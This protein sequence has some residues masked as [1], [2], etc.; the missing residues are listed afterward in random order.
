M[1]TRRWLAL[2]PTLLLLAGCPDSG[3]GGGGGQLAQLSKQ[4]DC[5][6]FEKDTDYGALV[7]TTTSRVNPDGSVSQVRGYKHVAIGT[8]KSA[9]PVKYCR[10]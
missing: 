6:T 1:R 5:H 4:Y 2:L 10:L 9:D 8:L 3:G 7:E